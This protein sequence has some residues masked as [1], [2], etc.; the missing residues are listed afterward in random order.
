MS[1]RQKGE[2]KALDNE[3]PYTGKR[4]CFWHI[5]GNFKST[6]KDKSMNGKL[7][8]ITR[9]G[10]K[11]VFIEHMKTL[12]DD[13][14]EVV[15]WLMKKL[16]EKWI[17]GLP[18]KHVIVV[19]MYKRVFPHDHVYW[20]CTKEALKLTYSSAINPI[21][22]ESSWPEYQCQHIDPPVKSVE[23]DRPKKNRK[24]AAYEP[25]APSKIFNNRC[26]THKTIGHNN[27]TCPDKLKVIPIH[28]PINTV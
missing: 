8:S 1:D 25:Q 14:M 5:L 17:S 16:C 6:F 23:V 27:R 4:N 12:G 2:L 7:W 9:A 15:L 28:M 13:S 22:E 20:Y 10:S 26:Q 19:F 18:Y 11:S 3:W 24:R 21:L